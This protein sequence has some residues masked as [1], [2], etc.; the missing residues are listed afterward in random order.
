MKEWG[1]F[2]PLLNEQRLNEVPDRPNDPTK[3]LAEDM[4]FGNPKEYM[5]GLDCG[6]LTRSMRQEF[7]Q[8]EEGKWKAEFE[9]VVDQEAI[10]VHETTTAIKRKFYERGL[11][12]GAI[13]RR[14]VGHARMRLEDFYRCRESKEA[15]LTTM[16][17]RPKCSGVPH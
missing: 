16:L 11:Q 6:S 10:E 12:N 3:M 4:I 9:Y 7:E 14:D 17:N 8:N 13:N 2:E 15:K 5:D 1:E